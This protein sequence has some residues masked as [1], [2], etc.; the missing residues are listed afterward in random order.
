MN[1]NIFVNKLFEEGKKAGLSDMEAYISKSNSITVSAFKNK[2]DKYSISD[3]MGLSFR[4]IYNGKMGYTYTERLEEDVIKLLVKDVIENASIVEKDDEEIIFKGSKE[5]TELDKNENKLES[6]SIDDKI[7]FI[8][9]LEKEAYSI[10]DRV[11]VVRN[12]IY[13]DENDSTAI[14]N[15]K[16]LKLDNSES[17]AYAYISVKV[18]DNGDIKTGLSYNICNDFNEL[19]YKK[20]AKE[21]V[22]DAISKLNAEV[23][24]SNKYKVILKNEAVCDLIESFCPIFSAYNV[25]EGLSLLKGKLNSKVA[26]SVFSLIDDPFMKESFSVR[27]FDDEGVAT[28]Y[29]RVIDKGVLTTYLYNLK[30]A[31]KDGVESTGNA[32]KPSYKSSITISPT[33]MY[34][35]KGN[36]TLEEMMLK[37]DDGVLLT[38]LQGSHAGLNTVSGDFSLSCNGFEIKGGKKVKAVNGIT[39]AGNFFDMIKN[40]EEVGTDFKF[41]LPSGSGCFGAPSIM[42]KDLAISGK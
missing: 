3:A 42:I 18:D 1:R 37:M 12:C 5:Y 2:L 8:L 11:D 36:M 34:V 27:N 25:Q 16:G 32:S 4:A 29:K 19:D 30:T 31:K 10:D 33:N 23:I 17:I 35:E 7:K 38:E 21:A 20:L 15:T 24:P 26:S 28:K 41:S 13:S 14:I 40:I 6:V 39:V 22:E 9:N